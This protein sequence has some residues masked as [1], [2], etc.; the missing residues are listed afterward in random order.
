MK[1]NNAQDAPRRDAIIPGS[2]SAVTWPQRLQLLLLL[3]SLLL[4]I[5]D[6]IPFDII[7]SQITEITALVPI[8]LAYHRQTKA[9]QCGSNSN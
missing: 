8:R 7:K 3:L 1:Q 2:L 5:L 9:N 6:R 4:F